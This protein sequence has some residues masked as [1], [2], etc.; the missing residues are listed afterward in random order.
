MFDT[1][2][3]LVSR[4]EGSFATEFNAQTKVTFQRRL[5]CR[6]VRVTRGVQQADKG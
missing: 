2:K 1:T 6:N 3:L 4:D 5:E